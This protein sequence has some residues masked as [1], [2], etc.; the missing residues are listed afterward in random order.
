MW[1][2][3]LQ[4]LLEPDKKKVDLKHHMLPAEKKNT[5]EKKTRVT[6][7]WIG[8]SQRFCRYKVSVEKDHVEAKRDSALAMN[9]VLWAD[10]SLKDV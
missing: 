9:Q 7:P 5:S 3:V 1:W 8:E 6:A 4:S 10:G 2:Y